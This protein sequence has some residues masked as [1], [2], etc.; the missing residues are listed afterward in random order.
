L[1]HPVAKN[2]P[3]YEEYVKA[4]NQAKAAKKNHWHVVT[5]RLI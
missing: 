5:F 1:N 3:Y 4:E 2:T